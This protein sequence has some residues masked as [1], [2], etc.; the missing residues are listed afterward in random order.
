MAARSAGLLVY[1]ERDGTIEVLLTHPGGPFWARKDEGAWTIPKGMIENGEDPLAT[2][3]REMQEE[4]GY[5]AGGEM[6]PLGSV[7]QAGGKVVE[8]W[9][10]RGDF[11]PALL[12]SNTFEMEWPPRSGMR[13]KFPEVDR[14]Q[15]FGWNAAERKILPSQIPLLQRLRDLLVK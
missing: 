10:V 2:A 11:D 12:K 5:R 4:T 13:R 8:A 14:A 3:V 7:K 15:W 1:R 6:L 9:A